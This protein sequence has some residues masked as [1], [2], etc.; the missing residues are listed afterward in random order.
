MQAVNV[1]TTI[2]VSDATR[3]RV[4]ELAAATGRRMQTIV[5]EAVTAYAR[6]LFWESFEASYAQIA[7]DP[8][9]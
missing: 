4:A 3:Q 1:S 2:R 7:D 9:R 8:E 5:D 6:T